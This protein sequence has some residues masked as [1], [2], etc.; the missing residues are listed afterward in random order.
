MAIY[1]H[2]ARVPLL[3]RFLLALTGQSALASAPGNLRQ[4]RE[5]SRELADH[6]HK[7]GQAVD[8]AAKQNIPLCL[9]T[10]GLMAHCAEAYTT[11][12]RYLSYLGGSKLNSNFLRTS[13]RMGEKSGV[14]IAEKAAD[15]ITSLSNQFPKTETPVYPKPVLNDP[16]HQAGLA[17][18]QH[19]QQLQD[20]A[21]GLIFN[22]NLSEAKVAQVVFRNSLQAAVVAAAIAGGCLALFG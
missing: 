19:G 13:F 5:E 20:Y 15:A 11:T 2:E 8:T 17:L 16:L 6:Y 9:N 1:T 22:I 18:I 21:D 12:R 3:T 4:L 7:V 10:H 14:E